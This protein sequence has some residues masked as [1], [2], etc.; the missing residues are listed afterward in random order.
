MKPRPRPAGTLAGIVV[1]AAFLAD[2][3]AADLTD[4][5][6][7]DGLRLLGVQAEPPE[8]DPGHPVTLTAWVVDTKGRAISVDW[9]WCTL[10]SNGLANPDCVTRGDVLVP[11]GTG[12]T[13]DI[14][15]PAVERNALGPPDATDGVYLPIVVH[16]R[17]VDDEVYAVYRLRILGTEPANKNPVITTIDGLGPE[18]TPTP[19][20]PGQAWSL[21]PMFDGPEKYWIPSTGVTATETLTAQWFATAGS[22]S[23][24]FGSNSPVSGY[25]AYEVFRLDRH[26]PQPGATID[27]W[28][29]G[30]DE[31]GGTALAHRTL[32]MQ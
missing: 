19:T 9:S 30:H 28:A 24:D 15:V 12:S 1:A 25:H 3:C 20:H 10:P 29:V 27:V 14:L 16:A 11:L 13:L 18:G 5:G 6:F 8:Q 7:V 4:A 31:R 21:L 2:G 23:E 26:L 22:F 17:V 32:L